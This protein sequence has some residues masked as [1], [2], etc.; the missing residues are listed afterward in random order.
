MTRNRG[1]VHSF[2]LFCLEI[3][4][5]INVMHG[6][7]VLDCTPLCAGYLVTA[8][9]QKSDISL[10]AVSFEHEIS[11]IR[12]VLINPGRK[13]ED[14]DTNM[15][16]TLPFLPYPAYPTVIPGVRYTSSTLSCL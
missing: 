16:S 10:A 6:C 4:H 15:T 12:M 1:G 14:A 13:G 3:K 5:P 8:S 2:N 9:L 7:L 11:K